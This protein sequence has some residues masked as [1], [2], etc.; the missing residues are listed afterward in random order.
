MNIEYRNVTLI[1][2]HHE[3]K[4]SIFEAL[5]RVLQEILTAQK[6]SPFFEALVKVLQ[7]ILTTQNLG[8]KPYPVEQ[9]H[10]TV[11][12]LE[13]VVE[14][15]LCYSKYLYEKGIRDPI[16]FNSLASFIRSHLAVPIC[17]SF[18]GYKRGDRSFMTLERQEPFQRSFYVGTGDVASAA[19]SGWPTGEPDKIDLLRRKFIEV[20]IGEKW[21]RPKDEVGGLFSVLGHWPKFK[22]D[23]ATRVP[24]VGLKLADVATRLRNFMEGLDVSVQWIRDCLKPVEIIVSHDKTAVVRYDDPALPLATTRKILVSK[25]DGRSLEELYR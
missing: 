3:E 11:M 6:K 20:N 13:A 24:F 15:G 14:S 4:A 17:V 1:T 25:L 18:G 5:V 22:N 19:I 9:I 21:P 7:K 16:D 2:Q 8:F 10:C 12:Q 23:P